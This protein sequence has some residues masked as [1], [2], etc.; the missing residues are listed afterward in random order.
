[1]RMRSCFLGVPSISILSRILL[2]RKPSNT[3]VGTSRFLQRMVQKKSGKGI[4][5]IFLK[6]GAM[7]LTPFVVIKVR[8]LGWFPLNH[9]ANHPLEARTMS[10]PSKPQEG[11]EQQLEIRD[12]K[13][14]SA[15]SGSR[16]ELSLFKRRPLNLEI[17][18]A[19][20]FCFWRFVVVV[21]RFFLLVFIIF[22]VLEVCRCSSV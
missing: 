13:D 18:G 14:H 11:P 21:S 20:D 9:S 7:I 15:G 5:P 6:T 22:L 8:S 16:V 17:S 1:M 10:L 12:G 3:Q 4:N 2:F 19:S